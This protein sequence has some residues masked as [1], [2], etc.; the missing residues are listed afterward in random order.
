MLRV[1]V[2]NI[3]TLYFLPHLTW[4]R[5][6]EFTF[7]W[8]RPL[9]EPSRMCSNCPL[10]PLHSRPSSQV[11]RKWWDSYLTSL[12]MKPSGNT[13]RR[14]ANLSSVLPLSFSTFLSPLWLKMPTP[15]KKIPTKGS[16]SDSRCHASA[17]W[18]RAPSRPAW[19]ANM[20]HAKLTVNH[21]HD[22]SCT[23][24][25]MEALQSRSG[26]YFQC[27]RS[28]Q[29]IAVISKGFVVVVWFISSFF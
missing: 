8:R 28:L 7:E 6:S 20:Q 27:C 15:T 2:W 23:H 17:S 14:S 24:T 9:E 21:W 16:V 3:V 13:E 5:P 4:K 12:Q 29:N 22:K 19:H 26:S 25:H 1:S 18:Q 11:S 10:Q